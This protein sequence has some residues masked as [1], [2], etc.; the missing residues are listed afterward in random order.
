MSIDAISSS[1]VQR[2]PA[3]RDDFQKLSDALKNGNLDAAQ[4]A[5]DKISQAQGS[6]NGPQPPAEIQDAFAAIGDALKSGDV[7]GAQDAFAQ[8]QSK[9]QAQRPA[10]PPPGGGGKGGGGG[11]EDDS[12]KTIDS[13]SSVTNANGT[14]TVTITYT[15][16][17]TSTRTDPNPNPVV[18]QGALNSANSG[19]LAAL[20]SAQ[21]DAV[22]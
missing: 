11:S 8:L 21:E 9:I 13:Q 5:Y 17:S 10:G 18:S 6:G 16:G 7:Q 2:P 4:S 22:S 12:S 15:D 14:V 20:I 19:Q 1:P 3:G